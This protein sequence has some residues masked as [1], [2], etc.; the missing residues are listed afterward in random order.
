MNDCPNAV[1]RDQLPDL[2]HD[3]LDPSARAAVM[4][5]VDACVD[6]REELDML[7]GVQGMLVSRGP[8]VDIPSIVAALPKPPVVRPETVEAQ[9]AEANVVPIRRTAKRRIWS[10]WRVAA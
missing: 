7:R 4:A 6:C 1:I 3:R 9:V 2:L 10:D 5:H 8:R